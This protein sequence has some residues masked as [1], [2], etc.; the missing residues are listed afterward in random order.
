MLHVLHMFSADTYPDGIAIWTLYLVLHSKVSV[1]LL[2]NIGL[3][4]SGLLIIL[5]PFFISYEL[6]VFYSIVLGLA[7]CKYTYFF[8]QIRKKNQL[9]LF[10]CFDKKACTAVTRPI[11]LG[12]LLGLENVNNAYGF[13]LVFYGVATLFGTPMAGTQT[14]I[15]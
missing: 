6:L 7:L 8:F 3:S 9:S 12:E 10:F 1:L 15:S 13:M 2:N 4:A 11:L 5:C 14:I